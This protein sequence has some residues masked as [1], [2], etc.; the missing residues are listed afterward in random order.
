MKKPRGTVSPKVSASGSSLASSV[1]GDGVFLTNS[2]TGGAGSR[3]NSV[4][5]DV[6]MFLRLRK[7]PDNSFE[8]ST[9]S[10]TAGGGA[11]APESSSVMRRD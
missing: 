1:C 3:A 8:I 7:I 4:L 11:T 10:V 2:T 5:T 6:S 9:L